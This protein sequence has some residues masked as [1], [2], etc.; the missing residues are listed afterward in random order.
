MVAHA[1]TAWPFFVLDCTA[2]AAGGGLGSIELT[3]ADAASGAAAGP[4][5]DGS[6]PPGSSSESGDED[7]GGGGDAGAA[8][9]APQNFSR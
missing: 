3:R 8:G 6:T 5:W 2:H 4:K 1:T 7:S 9:E